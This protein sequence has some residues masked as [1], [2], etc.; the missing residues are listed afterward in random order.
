MTLTHEYDTDTARLTSGLVV[1]PGK[2]SDLQDLNSTHQ[3]SKLMTDP[4]RD[5]A[6]EVTVSFRP[7]ELSAPAGQET[8]FELA[9]EG[10]DSGISAYESA[11]HIDEGARID[12]LELTGDPAVPVADVVDGESAAVVAAAMGPESDHGPAEEAVI[13]E[14]V[15]TGETAG[16]S[17]GLSVEDDTEVAPIGDGSERYTVSNCGAA[18]LTVT[19]GDN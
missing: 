5:D 9:V 4:D 13:A 10:A 2:G 6:G 19:D 14:V 11:V 3:N 8:V 15:V 12:R 17:V 7:A 16:A 1:L 18:M